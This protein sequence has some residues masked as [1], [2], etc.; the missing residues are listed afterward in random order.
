[1]EIIRFEINLGYGKQWMFIEGLENPRGIYTLYVGGFD[2]GTI[3][4]YKGQW[5]PQIVRQLEA[6]ETTIKIIR[7]AIGDFKPII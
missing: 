1:M 4:Y 3:T 6:T 5:H 7:E 2:V